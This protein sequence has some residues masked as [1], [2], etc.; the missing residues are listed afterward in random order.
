MFIL[1]LGY[2]SF[3]SFDAAK[4]NLGKSGL[5]GICIYVHDRVQA[6]QVSSR[7]PHFAEHLRLE[8]KLRGNDKLL[9][10]CVYRKPLRDAHLSVDELVHLHKEVHLSN[11]S[12]LL[13][14]G[15][16]DL[17]QIDWTTCFCSASEFHHAHNI[18]MQFM[19]MR[20]LFSITHP[21]R[22]RFGEAPSLLDLVLTNE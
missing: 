22:Y 8:M 21:K 14:T 18:L 20:A 12:H 17:P 19:G 3:T 5:R 10:G 13:V 7:A 6:A 2:P 15:D 1:V 11:P 16:Y 9:V 4:S